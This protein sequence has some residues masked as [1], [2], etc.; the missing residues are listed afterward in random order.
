M[1][2]SLRSRSTPLTHGFGH[3]QED[4][5]MAM[6]LIV[7]EQKMRDAGFAKGTSGWYYPK[8]QNNHI[9]LGAFTGP[10][11]PAGH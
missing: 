6:R 9:H 8:E 11:V 7:E 2:L 1:K 4:I 10:G 5:E 3:S